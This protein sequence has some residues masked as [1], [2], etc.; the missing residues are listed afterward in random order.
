MK[1]IVSAASV[2]RV[3]LALLVSVAACANM[4]K[5]GPQSVAGMSPDGTVTMTEIIAAGA[6]AGKGTLY[7]QGRS[8]SFKLVGGVTGGDGVGS[9]ET[10]GEG[11]G[12][13][14]GLGDR[15]PVVHV[16]QLH[17]GEAAPAHGIGHCGRCR[18]DEHT[19]PLHAIGHGRHEALGLC[20][21]KR[22]RAM[23][24]HDG[25]D[26]PG[27]GIHAGGNVRRVGETAELEARGF[28]RVTHD[29]QRSPAM[30]RAR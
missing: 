22:P 11:H 24:G 23:G 1:T 20:G 7:F 19:H 9:V 21:I 15:R 3:A 30:R 13:A 16:V 26:G 29:G 10:D 17:S 25:A 18:I 12:H 2:R 28:G 6:A 5:P 8:H 14:R 27:A 4:E